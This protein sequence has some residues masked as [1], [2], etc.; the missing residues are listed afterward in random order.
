MSTFYEQTTTT[1]DIHPVIR[2]RA[3]SWVTQPD[4]SMCH[5]SGYRQATILQAIELEADPDYSRRPSG[6]MDLR[7]SAQKRREWLRMLLQNLSDALALLRIN[8][9]PPMVTLENDDSGDWPGKRWRRALALHKGEEWSSRK[10]IVV[11]KPENET[12]KNG[13][14][15]Y[16]EV[17]LEIPRYLLKV[18]PPT[19]S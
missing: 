14:S 8:R 1:K 11:P 5:F 17:P 19:E 15:T 13:R 6:S 18:L 10:L 2:L 12:G 16:P 4:G 9:H 3:S 7:T